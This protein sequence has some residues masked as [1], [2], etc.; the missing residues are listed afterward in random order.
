LKE[1]FYSLPREELWITIKY[2]YLIDFHEEFIDVLLKEVGLEYFDLHL[3]TTRWAERSSSHMVAPWSDFFTV[4]FKRRA[5][6]SPLCG[7]IVLK[8]FLGQLFKRIF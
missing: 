4:F 5:G 6:L 2:D 8:Y 7:T 1:A 3:I